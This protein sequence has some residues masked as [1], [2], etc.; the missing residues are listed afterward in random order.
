MSAVSG[1]FMTQFQAFCVSLPFLFRVYVK[2]HITICV[3]GYFG[4][5]SYG[6]LLF[7]V[8]AVCTF[9]EDM[10]RPTFYSCVLCASGGGSKVEKRVRS[11]VKR[12][13]SRRPVDRSWVAFPGQMHRVSLSNSSL[14]V[15]L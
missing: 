11:F 8:P 9:P 10:F 3:C 14:A 5:S 4:P 2:L 13:W 7:R 15:L 1:H 6:Y 12:H